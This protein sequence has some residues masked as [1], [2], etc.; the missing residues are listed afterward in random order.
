MMKVKYLLLSL[1]LLFLF[2]IPAQAEPGPGPAAF[3]DIEGS[4]AVDAILELAGQGLISGVSP[5][6]FAP[7]QNISRKHFAVL[8]AR[9]LGV[10]PFEPA[11]NTF[12]DIHAGSAEAAYV[13]ALAELG[14]VTGTGGVL[15]GAEDPVTRQ[16][17]AVL[18]TRALGEETELPS[19]AGRYLD[20]SRIA[21][22]AVKTCRALKKSFRLS[23]CSPTCRKIFT[24]AFW[25]PWPGKVWP[26]RRN[27]RFMKYCRLEC[28]YCPRKS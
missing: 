19:L 8:L 24:G 1:A 7:E 9:V 20:E 25:K 23:T 4:F 11:A 27:I 21:P 10:Q 18:L 2:G 14:L 16:D 15:M 3:Q 28:G 13:G 5:G 22:Y 12:Q 26:L 6:V 17:T